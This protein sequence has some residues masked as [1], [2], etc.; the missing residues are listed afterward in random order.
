MAA[1]GTGIL[2]AVRRTVRGTARIKPHFPIATTFKKVKQV[3]YP[4]V[5][6]FGVSTGWESSAETQ[7]RERSLAEDQTTTLL[8]PVLKL[9]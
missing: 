1:G 3:S 4:Q 5:T 7:R 6:D 2:A 9:P 8:K